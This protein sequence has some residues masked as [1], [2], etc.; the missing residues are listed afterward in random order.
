M[1]EEVIF[2]HKHLRESWGYLFTGKRPH[3][4]HPF[5]HSTYVQATQCLTW[6]TCVWHQG[7]GTQ[8]AKS[9]IGPW[10]SPWGPHKISF[11]T[12]LISV[13]TII[14]YGTVSR[15]SIA[16]FRSLIHRPGCCSLCLF[17]CLEHFPCGLM[18]RSTYAMLYGIC[19]HVDAT[20]LLL[21]GR[22]CWGVTG[23]GSFSAGLLGLL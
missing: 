13:R 1:E 5:S 23:L 20:L 18:G 17:P 14:S 16:N 7:Q 2:L 22:V 9:S 15:V 12:D 11:W 10:S 3:F 4:I 21:E 6:T 8:A 19:W